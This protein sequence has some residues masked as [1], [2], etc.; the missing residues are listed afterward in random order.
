MAKDPELLAH[1]QW[2]GY[3]QPVGL[4][5]S[6]PALLQG[7]AYVNRNVL[8]E[9]QRFLTHVSEVPV[10]GHSEPLPAVKS[11]RAL[12]LDVFGWQ[13]GD[14][15]EAGDP[16]AAAI[17][18][19]LPEYHE[20]L[21][22]THAVPEDQGAEKPTWM[23]LIQE[24]EAG[25]PLDEVV[26][27]DERRWE[28]TPQARFE[29]LLRETQVPIGLLSSGTHLRLVYYPRGESPGHVTF[30]VPAMTEVAGRPIFAALLMLL[31]A[32]RMFSLPD[33]Q[34]LPTILAESRK[35]QNTVSTELAK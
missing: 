33:K 6:S 25:T 18:V 10:A 20:T 26:E 35:Y 9:H 16:R 14:L 2:L 3:L 29:R 24:L 12:L 27:K 21:R 32:E 15:V 28:A 13:P 30:P 7:Q 5:V 19:V 1:Q 17:E 34:R 4:V 8:A 31:S 23:M 11:L 22:P